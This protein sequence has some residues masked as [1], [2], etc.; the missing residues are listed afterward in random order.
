MIHHHTAHPLDYLG[1]S[2]YFFTVT[3]AH[4]LPHLADSIAAGDVLDSLLHSAVV[5]SFAID[6]YC[7]MPDHVHILAE[8]LRSVS[9]ALAFISH[10]K[11]HTSLPFKTKTLQILWEFSYHNHIL[12]PQ[13]S[14]VEVARYIWWNPIRKNLCHYPAEYPFSGSQTINWLQAAATRPTWSTPWSNQTQN[15]K[16]KH[17]TASL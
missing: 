9:D 16:Q 6:P 12:R 8:G 5:K 17:A 2:T 13:D 7:L 10:F 14:M 15:Q 1:R 4:R 11:Q 3:C